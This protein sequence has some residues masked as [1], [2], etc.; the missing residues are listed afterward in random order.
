MN[1]LAHSRLSDFGSSQLSVFPYQSQ[2]CNLSSFQRLSTDNRFRKADTPTDKRRRDT[3]ISPMRD[4]LGPTPPKRPSP[5]HPHQFALAPMS[6]FQ[7]NQQNGQQHVPAS[8]TGLPPQQPQSGSVDS[9]LSAH[10][11]GTVNEFAEGMAS[12]NA[13]GMGNG[14]GNGVAGGSGNG[15]G[16]AGSVEK[17]EDEMVEEGSKKRRRRNSNAGN[18][19]KFPCTWEGCGK[20]FSRPDHLSRHRLNHTPSQIY[21]CDRCAKVFVRGESSPLPLSSELES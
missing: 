12:D 8:L 13:M 11:N 5:T 9:M 2:S 15:S 17:E 3:V 14:N 21:S 16:G 19:R 6:N 4:S 7:Q 10:R 1:E 20:V 18:G